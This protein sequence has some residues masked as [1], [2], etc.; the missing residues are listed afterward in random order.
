MM[1]AHCKWC[2]YVTVTVSGVS[3]LKLVQLGVLCVIC[4]SKFLCLRQFCWSTCRSIIDS[5]NFSLVV[6]FCFKILLLIFAVFYSYKSILSNDG[7][8]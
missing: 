5:V 2:V 1:S 8:F 4:L 7:M 6:R 3:E